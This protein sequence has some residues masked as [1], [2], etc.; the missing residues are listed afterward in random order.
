MAIMKKLLVC[1]FQVAWSLEAY[2]LFPILEAYSVPSTNIKAQSSQSVSWP[3]QTWSSIGSFSRSLPLVYSSCVLVYSTNGTWFILLVK[4]VRKY[5]VLVISSRSSSFLNFYC[6]YFLIINWKLSI[7]FPGWNDE[8]SFFSG[9][10][11]MVFQK[12]KTSNLVFWISHKLNPHQFLHMDI[13]S[14]SI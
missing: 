10:Y 3:D 12:K 2:N 5:F 1:A 7:R 11:A 6:R 13:D 4:N 14:N 8:F 9:E